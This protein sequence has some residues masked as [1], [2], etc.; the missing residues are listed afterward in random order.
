MYP[1]RKYNK[2]EGSIADIPLDINYPTDATKGKRKA[3]RVNIRRK[4]VGYRPEGY[5]RQPK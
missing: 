2:P 1:R 4:V 3:S 5:N